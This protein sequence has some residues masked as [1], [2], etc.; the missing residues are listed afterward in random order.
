MSY[1]QAR[2]RYPKYIKYLIKKR[3]NSL[4][5]LSENERIYLNVPYIAREFAQFSHCGFDPERKLW[6]TGSMNANLY[7]LVNLYG[8]NKATSKKAM[9]L[10][11]VK[12][13]EN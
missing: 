5:S 4:P 10:L 13:E 2:K 3:E 11:K 7:S 6:F 12:L 1:N 8:I 9:K